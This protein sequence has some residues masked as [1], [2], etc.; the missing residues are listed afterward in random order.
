VSS[1]INADGKVAAAIKE[2]K[3]SKYAMLGMLTGFHQLLLR[4]WEYLDTF[5]KE[6]GTEA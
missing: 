4:T 1:G 3:A 2:R 5:V 6:L